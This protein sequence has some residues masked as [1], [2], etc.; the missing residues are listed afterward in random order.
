MV[1]SF[2]LDLD[3]QDGE[4][5][6]GTKAL[7]AKGRVREHCRYLE[8]KVAVPADRHALLRRAQGAKTGRAQ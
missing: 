7:G 4:W 2:L 3:L 6:L 8:V 5:C 1:W